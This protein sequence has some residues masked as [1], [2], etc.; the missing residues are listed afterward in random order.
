MK[1]SPAQAQ[2]IA[3]RNQ[4]MVV[5]AGAGSGK[6][7]VLVERVLSLLR[8]DASLT[9][10][11]FLVMT[12]TEAAAGEMR[13]RLANGI[14]AAIHEANDADDSILAKRLGRELDA[15]WQAQ[16]STIH[17]FCLAV[18]EQN[19]TA[20]ARSPKFRLMAD[21]EQKIALRRY[22]Q[23]AIEAAL[24]DDS[25]GDA[26]RS[27][28]S[29]LRLT[30]GQALARVLLQ[31]Y[32]L[33]RAQVDSEAWLNDV[34]AAYP[35]D[36]SA[37]L[38]TAF[39][40]VFRIWI[41]DM[42]DRAATPIQMAVGIA[43][44]ISELE[45]A[46]TWLSA[47]NDA[48]QFARELSER[49]TGNFGEIANALSFFEGRA[50][51]ISYKGPEADEVKALRKTGTDIVKKTLLPVLER[52][53]AALGNDLVDIGP[54]IRALCALCQRLIAHAKARKERDAVFDFNDLEH[55][56]YR[57]LSAD[58][59]TALARV[60]S[61][62]VH[63]FVDEY[64]D[65]S[66][67]QDAIV[68]LMTTRGDGLFAVGDVKQS[69][70]RFRMAE[71]G[72][73][74][75]RYERYR[76]GDGGCSID[77]QD[78]Y[79][80]RPEIVDW[81][82]FSF[83][84][85]FHPDTTG[86]SYD[87]RIEMRSMAAYPEAQ[88]GGAIVEAHLLERDPARFT[89]VS[90]DGEDDAAMEGD[91]ADG[92]EIDET[93]LE[94]EAALVAKRIRA[95]FDAGA[96]VY[97]AKRGEQRPLAFD[98]IAILMRSGRAALNVVIDTLALDGIPAA[99]NT[100]TG[101]YEAMEIQWLIQALRAIDNPLDGLALVSLL[102]SP[103]VGW[104]ETLLAK[105]RLLSKGSFWYAVL[106]GARG[107][108][109]G[110]DDVVE[111]CR[112]FVQTFEVWRHQSTQVRVGDLIRQ[113]LAETSL[114]LYLEGMPQGRIRRANVQQLL[115][116]VD[117][118]DASEP[119][120]S[121]FTFLARFR[122]EEDANLDVGAAAPPEANR[123]QVMTIHR[124]KGLEFPVVFVIDLGKQF[125]L[126]P[127]DLPM[128]RKLGVGANAFDIATGQR[129]R[130]MASIAAAYAEA[131]ETLA[132]EARILYVAFTRAKERLIL[133]GSARNLAGQV[134]MAAYAHDANQ[135]RLT[136][137]RFF[138]AHTYMDWLLPVLLRHPEAGELRGMVGGV[139][140]D[141]RLF[142]A[143]RGGLAVKV[144]DGR[145]VGET[146][147][148]L[149]DVDS[150]AGGG[151]VRVD[152]ERHLRELQL[153]PAR[154]HVVQ[155]RERTPD[156]FAQIFS[157]VTATDMRRLHVAT[158]G[159]GASRRLHANAATSLLEDPV[160]VRDDAQTPR[161]RGIAF[162][163]FM[164]RCAWPVSPS[165]PELARELE[166]LVRT[167]QLLPDL[168]NA[169]QLD[170]IAAFLRSELGQNMRLATRF[171]REQPFFH[172]IDVP[173]GEH[174][175]KVVSIVAQGVIDC[176]F[177]EA[178]RWVVV[179]Y[180]TD[181]VDEKGV[182]S[183]AREYEAQV[184]TYLAALKPLM[185]D[186]PVT[187]YLYFVRPGQAVTVPPMELSEVFL[188]LATGKKSDETT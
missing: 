80:S 183:L 108:Q 166:R 98:D 131:R 20:L 158:A 113:L 1:W 26:M 35:E 145:D 25:F 49:P 55:D 84:Q 66:P 146:D 112:K 7:A 81:I 181:R 147:V 106:Q 111:A 71:P 160:F 31:L 43:Q 51:S 77:L 95:L 179:D 169:V 172:R 53:D 5:S 97:D 4:H 69:I 60:R 41:R 70:Y 101:F 15:L 73:F 171:Y 63:V 130:T 109:E 27:M 68:D 22:A 148:R 21:N 16:I 163:A 153:D 174:G 167:G 79:R 58:D 30:D 159:L 144:Y 12:F 161:D 105:V 11:R 78:N 138:A 14:E 93:A 124:S 143:A 45:K 57:I 42:L 119:M 157:K 59:G 141:G 162:H 10:E 40:D 23:E 37:I 46:A 135:P 87:E 127:D 136:S 44:S 64:Q 133:V 47:A 165:E 168:A 180:K 2:A 184:A 125:R 107:N 33:A 67:I 104:D 62:Y 150:N 186:K 164:Q 88:S 92:D 175:C 185:R 154:P 173:A 9:M 115:R 24:V 52:G 89:T 91:V 126:R 6:T 118:H 156:A 142:P 36:A 170:D 85:L 90:E 94:R 28:M 128:H 56:A 122:Q 65:T 152:W 86:F 74:L 129:W 188:R 116:M 99:G 114:I 123:V 117:E 155:I 54:H 140:G 151:P 100:S 103:L 39:S 132:E 34:A 121:L 102:R 177:E 75:S 19:P 29:Y 149:D 76:R 110:D 8:E 182:P 83:R 96:T 3:L 137:S 18:I 50:A 176:L 139:S 48:L 13:E 178:D 61:K 82:N 187:A 38:R 17:S 120:A 32:E 134:R 72:L